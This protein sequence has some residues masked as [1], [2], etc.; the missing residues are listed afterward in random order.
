METV[1]ILT[2]WYLI[3]GAA[4][5]VL[6][7]DIGKMRWYEKILAFTCWPL[8]LPFSAAAVVIIKTG[9]DNA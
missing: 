8:V 7:N 9:I 4:L 1:V 2:M 6:M 3:C 5:V